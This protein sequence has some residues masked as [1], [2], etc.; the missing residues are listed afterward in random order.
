[1]AQTKPCSNKT[2]SDPYEC[3][4]KSDRAINCR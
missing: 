2:G 3:Q 4:R 1:M